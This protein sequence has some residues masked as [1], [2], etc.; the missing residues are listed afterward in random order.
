LIASLLLFPGCGKSPIEAQWQF[1]GVADTGKMVSDFNKILFN[2]SP[3]TRL[4]MRETGIIGKSDSLI[5][6]SE[7]SLLINFSAKFPGKRRF[8]GDLGCR[9]KFKIRYL[10]GGG[11]IFLKEIAMTRLPCQ[12]NENFL[13]MY[14]E[15]LFASNEYRV[16][17]DTLILKNLYSNEL[18]FIKIGN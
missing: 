17:R 4:F 6:P 7:T 14:R 16:S 2:I 8:T 10:S 11:K 3:D 12:A 18:R 1:I 9:N 13:F 15:Y 5:I